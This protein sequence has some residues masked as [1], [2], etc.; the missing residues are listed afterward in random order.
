MTPTA[1]WSDVI[2][3]AATALEKEDIGTPWLGNYLL[4]KPR[5]LPP[6]GLARDDYEILCDLAGRIGFGAEFSEGRSAAEWVRHFIDTSEIDDPEGFTREGIYRGK[7]TDRAGL[8]DFA[9][10]PERFP[11]KT[12]SGKVEISS[13]AFARDSGYSAIPIWRAAPED[14]AYPLLLVTPKSPHRT[15]SQWSNI[16]RVREKAAHA[17]EMHRKDAQ[18]RGIADGDE[19]FLLNGRGRSRVKVRLVVDMAPGVVCLHEGVW[20]EA[21]GDGVDL[22]GSANM[23]TSS[24]GTDASRACV[25]HAIGV[26]VSAVGNASRT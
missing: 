12:P 7:A 8:S 19:A 23:F 24:E 14:P 18:S 11:L 9:A 21:D 16:A 13:E 22:A 6:R 10:D 4:Y 15:H 20:H 1:R 26:E 17:L 5:V 3:P 2:L 25:M